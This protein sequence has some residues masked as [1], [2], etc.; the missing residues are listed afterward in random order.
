MI[1]LSDLDGTLMNSKGE[2]TIEDVEAIRRWTQKH[3]FGFVT[4]RD[5]A[6]CDKLAQKYQL[7]CDCM[8]TDNGANAFYKQENVYSSL[9]DLDDGMQMCKKILDSKVD[10]F[11][12]DEKGN[13]YYPIQAYGVDRLHVFEKKQPSLG[14]FSNIDILE[15]LKNRTVGLAKI[16]MYVEADFELLLDHFKRLFKDY[17]V[18]ATSRDYIE[19]TRKDT[20]KWE[21]FCHLP[22]DD[23]IFIGDGENDLCI[24]KNL[25]DTYV[26]NHAPDI[27]K[28]YGVGV[29]SVAQAINI[30]S[31]KEHV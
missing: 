15:Y 6:F 8:I 7:T 16:S 24:L 30:E 23:A 21:A 9:I 5:K 26:M 4:G 14:T 27:V 1:F 19:I 25:K 13:R 20:N 10:V 28:A 31:R 18:M 11:Y 29:M 22:I 12:T 3:A 17:E 2:I